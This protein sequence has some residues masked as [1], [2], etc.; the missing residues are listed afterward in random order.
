MPR[1]VAKACRQPI[2]GDTKEGP[3]PKTEWGEKHTCQSCGAL[4]YDLKKKQPI[5]PKCETP[6]Q[7]AKPASRRQAATAPPPPPP[8]PLEKGVSTA[9]TESGVI[10]TPADDTDDDDILENDGD[11][12]TLIEDE[13]DD[14]V[15]EVV[16]T[17]FDS[18]AEEKE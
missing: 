5:C 13:E 8:P 9:V 6:L 18:G 2:A 7:A 15:S 14:D 1:N 4:Y 17:S 10:E 12:D 16:D 11:E 3:L